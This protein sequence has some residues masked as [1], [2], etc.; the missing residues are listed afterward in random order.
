MDAT[1][2]H[3][4]PQSAGGRDHDSN[5]VLACYRCNRLANEVYI[6]EQLILA[7]AGRAD[8]YW[9]SRMGN[10]R[11]RLKK[12]KDEFDKLRAVRSTDKDHSLTK[13]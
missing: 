6:Y 2:E 4:I 7:G 12:R 3:L 8:T 11:D 9:T 1:V 10:W 5:M 13:N